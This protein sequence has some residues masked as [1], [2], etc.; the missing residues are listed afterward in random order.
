MNGHTAQLP[1]ELAGSGI[2]HLSLDDAARYEERLAFDP[3]DEIELLQTLGLSSQST[4]VEFGPGPGSFA[5]AAARVARSVVAVDPSQ[6]MCTYLEQRA[7]ETNTTNLVV[8]NAGFLSYIHE[9]PPVDFVFSKNALHHLPDFWKVAALTNVSTILRPSGVLRLRDLVYSFAPQDADRRIADW[10]ASY[11]ATSGWGPEDLA[12]HVR[13]EFSTYG[14]ILEGMLE[15]TGFDIVERWISDSEVF[16][17]YT[18]RRTE[19]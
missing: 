2:A 8:V 19:Q 18:C 15:R 5:L 13:D 9:S 7:A 6:A 1:D 16:A 10:I 12:H 4:M 14:W 17:R 3:T 11:G